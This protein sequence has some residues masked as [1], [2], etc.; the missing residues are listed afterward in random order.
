[1]KFYGKMEE[2]K[3]KIYNI[4]NYKGFFAT[5]QEGDEFEIKLR[6]VKDIRNLEMNNLYWMWLG[7]LS[8]FSGYTKREL[9]SYFKQELLCHETQVNGEAVHDCLSTT[10]LSIKEFSKYLDEV[11]RLSAQNFHFT[12]SKTLP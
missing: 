1:M 8:D 5:L 10:D 6:K 7:Q 12:L 4:D 3:P 2:G 11:A 9:H